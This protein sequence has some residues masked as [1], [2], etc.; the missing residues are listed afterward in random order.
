[1][2]NNQKLVSQIA[3]LS[4]NLNLV[5][6]S[7][8]RNNQ[9]IQ[10]LIE[11]QEDRDSN[12]GPAAE[13]QAAG[14]LSISKELKEIS[15]TLSKITSPDS[16][17]SK[18][19]DSFEKSGNKTFD[20]TSKG[21]IK[22]K[23]QTGG[24]AKEDG[25]YLVGENGPEV[26]A[27]PKGSGVIPI[28]AKDLIEGLRKVPE[29]SDLLK[30]GDSVNV[31]GSVSNRDRAIL[32]SDGKRI[33]LYKL[34]E[35]YEDQAIDAEDSN[36]PKV[37]DTL[38]KIKGYLKSLEDLDSE[39]N[40]KLDEQF[41]II[42]E[43]RLKLNEKRGAEGGTFEE[44]KEKE[45]ILDQIRKTISPEDYTEL[46][47]AKANLQAEKIVL[48][49]KT[50]AKTEK[51]EVEAGS[52][53]VA[54]KTDLKKLNTETKSSEGGKS[55]KESEGS[56]KTGAEK[57]PGIFSKL[58]SQL[59]KS[60]GR[61]AEGVAQQTGL[62]GAFSLAKKG[63]G[64]LSE[65]M[66]SEEQAKASPATATTEAPKMEKSVSKLS[67]AAPKPET[68]QEA[69]KSTPPPSPAPVQ[70]QQNTQTGSMEQSTAAKASKTS[71]SSSGGG[72]QTKNV[73]TDDL[74][75]IKGTLS[76]IAFLLEGPLTFS[77]IEDPYRPNSRR[78]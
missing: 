52:K 54:L 63:V 43:E 9:G 72:D 69:P 31:T 12:P 29:L 70:S 51:S 56:E 67:V 6:E 24:I 32:S 53:T 14:M 46:G 65:K 68:T 45:K 71:T 2:D 38:Q 40:R 21:E 36:D 1:M 4:R 37:K 76:R 61:V 3:D 57:G 73:T 42:R 19:A 39:A 74:D 34:I 11:I 30:E 5:N 35:N 49:K 10:S 60:A 15:S 33:S 20:F 41:N 50:E 25:K 77:Q 75:T 64:A 66:K 8:K 59:K 58:G 44:F 55:D 28:N 22:G 26:V 78:V 27:L 17:F 23:F 62:G 47:L 13:N 48:S 18:M 16:P 7:I